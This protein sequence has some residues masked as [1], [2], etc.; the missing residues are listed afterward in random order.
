[1]IVTLM[2]F[3]LLVHFSY[4]IPQQ[5]IGVAQNIQENGR[6]KHCPRLFFRL[7]TYFI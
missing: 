4:F 3:Q 7:I 6:W 5:Y 1:M 2:Y